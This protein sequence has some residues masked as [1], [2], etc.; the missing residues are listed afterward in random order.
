M[1][2]YNTTISG[3]ECQIWLCRFHWFFGPTRSHSTGFISKSNL[4]WRSLQS[5]FPSCGV[6]F[7]PAIL[8]KHGLQLWLRHSTHGG[9]VFSPLIQVNCASAYISDLARS[10]MTV[11]LS[12]VSIMGQTVRSWRNQTKPRPRATHALQFFFFLP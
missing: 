4:R 2:L 5:T 9:T 6:Q 1:A 11:V 7:R 8:D 10:L 3:N 12:Q